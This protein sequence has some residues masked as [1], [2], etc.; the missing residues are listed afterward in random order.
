MK[1][2]LYNG[3]YWHCED[4]TPPRSLPLHTPEG[5]PAQ[6]ALRAASQ[7]VEDH[8]VDLQGYL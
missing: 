8:Q 1:P 6:K 7:A 2:S 3:I 4:N 5:L